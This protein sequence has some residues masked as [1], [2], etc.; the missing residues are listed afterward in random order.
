MCENWE[1]KEF[2]FH[3]EVKSMNFTFEGELNKLGE[4]GWE[5]IACNLTL[6]KGVRQVLLKRHLP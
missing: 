4:Q 6:A 3:G 2:W 1:Y 5:V